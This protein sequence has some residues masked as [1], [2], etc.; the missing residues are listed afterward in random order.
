L[1]VKKFI[2]NQPLLVVVIA[3]QVFRFSMLPIMGLMPQDAYYYFYGQHLA[4]SYF[5]HPGMIGYAL[6]LFSE[7]FGQSTFVVNLTDF[8]ITSL[9]LIAFYKLSKLF[10]SKQK[11]N[12][13]LVLMSSS[14]MISILSI[15]STPDV[16]L[17]LFWTLSLIALYKAVFYNNFKQWL[18]AGLFMG[19]AFDS[20]YTSIFLQF[21]LIAFLILSKEHRKLL[22]SK[23]FISSIFLSVITAFPVLYWNYKHQFV[24]FLFQSTQR[25]ESVKSF[26]IKPL[27]F[28][29]TVGHELLI[30][31]PPLFIF[32]VIITY[33]ILKKQL[34]KWKFPKAPQLFL[35]CFFLPTFLGFFGISLFYWVKINWMM[36]AYISGIIFISIYISKK[37]IKTNTVFAIIIHMAIAVEILFYV[38][39]VKSDDTWFGWEQLAQDVLKIQ[40]E[41]TN[42]FIFSADN[43]KTTAILNFYLNQPIYGQNIIGEF[44][45]QYNFIGDDLSKLN[46]KNALF[47]NSDKRIKN[48]LKSGIIPTKL[49]GYFKEVDELNPILIKHYGKTVRKFWVYYA[50]GYQNNPIK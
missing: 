12:N 27:S 36:P 47:I 29:G 16:P 15:I 6:R 50:K 41:H 45:L 11:Q 22:I 33:K 28:L 7:V 42:S 20:K 34:L 25:A 44:A 19:L 49:K 10:L 24:S 5:D 21:G 3:F 23:G 46:G 8:T 48:N 35:L 37:W 31:I 13:A 17:L 39:P 38:V 1:K 2:Q 26:G 32:M 9:T 14:V 40:Q 18:L 30:L 43:Y 4:L